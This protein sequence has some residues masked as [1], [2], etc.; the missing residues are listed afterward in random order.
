VVAVPAT[1]VIL[2]GTAGA[3]AEVYSRPSFVGCSI[4]REATSFATNSYIVGLHLKHMVAC[5]TSMDGGCSVSVYRFDGQAF[6]Y[7]YILSINTGTMSSA[8]ATNN[9]NVASAGIIYCLLNSFI[10]GFP[11]GTIEVIVTV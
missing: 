8:A 3:S 6:G 10:S 1:A 9:D 11:A 4:D 7:I 5:Y 2:D